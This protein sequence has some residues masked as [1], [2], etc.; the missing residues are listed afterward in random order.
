VHEW[1]L[2]EGIVSTAVRIAREQGCS[3]ITRIKIRLGELQ[4]IDTGIF[5]TLLKEVIQTQDSMAA[6]AE[7]EIEEEKAVMKCRVCG[8]EWDFDDDLKGLSEEEGESIHFVPEIAHVYITCPACESP[9][10]EFVKGRGVWLD[11]IEGE[12]N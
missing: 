12:E 4:Q 7:I 10:F 2:A 11:S 6:G 3:D 5:E 1:A 8:R 9:D